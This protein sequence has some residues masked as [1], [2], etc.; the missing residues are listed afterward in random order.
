MPSNIGGA[1]FSI[2]A[3]KRGK[4][5]KGKRRKREKGK[6][7]KGEKKK[8]R[9][10]EKKNRGKEEKEKE[11]KEKRGKEEKEKRGKEEKKKKGKGEKGKRIGERKMGKRVKRE[12]CL[13]GLLSPQSPC[14][15]GAPVYTRW[16]NGGWVGQRVSCQCVK[17]VK[18]LKN[19]LNYCYI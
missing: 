16:W 19:S 4:E 9:D 15:N 11:E 2:S 5:E 13:V 6:S 17:T 1:Q 7:R 10:V 3:S 18:P 8:R 12:T 14:P